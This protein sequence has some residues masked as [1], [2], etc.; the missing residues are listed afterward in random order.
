MLMNM[1]CNHIGTIVLS[2]QKNQYTHVLHVQGHG[3]GERERGREER[4]FYRGHELC[5]ALKTEQCLGKSSAGPKLRGIV[6]WS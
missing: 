2:T 6:S 4:G 1:F 5:V 3:F